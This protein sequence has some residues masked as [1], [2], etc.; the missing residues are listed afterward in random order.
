[1]KEIIVLIQ[2]KIQNYRSSLMNQRKR[3]RRDSRHSS[4]SPMK[5]NIKKHVLDAGKRSASLKVRKNT[6]AINAQDEINQDMDFAQMNHVLRLR[7][8]ICQ[9]EKAEL[10]KQ[11]KVLSYRVQKAE[12]SK[13]K[14][15]AVAEAHKYLKARFHLLI[16]KIKQYSENRQPASDLL[17]VLSKLHQLDRMASDEKKAISN[18][19]MSRNQKHYHSANE[20]EELKQQLEAL[21]E[22][23]INSQKSPGLVANLDKA[24]MPGFEDKY[25]SLRKANTL[26][27]AS[28]ERKPSSSSDFKNRIISF[29]NNNDFNFNQAA[30]REVGVQ[31]TLSMLAMVESGCQT[32]AQIIDVDSAGSNYVKHVSLQDMSAFMDK[33]L[34]NKRMT[35]GSNPELYLPQQSISSSARGLPNH[36][37][38]IQTPQA[39]EAETSNYRSS[40]S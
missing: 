24:F 7:V 25:K 33:Q 30:P 14:H 8:D 37:L 3:N 23:E 27:Q 9:D 28:L 31:T 11:L 35:F 6:N 10:Q 34:Q 4:P 19:K 1:M 26:E 22:S 20:L 12:D 36:E 39:N 21:T 16:E 15:E 32:F 40:R 29:G 18:S 38:E 5:T 13:L 17:K 2:H